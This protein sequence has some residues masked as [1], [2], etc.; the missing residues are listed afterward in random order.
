MIFFNKESHYGELAYEFHLSL[1]MKTSKFKM[2]TEGK[3]TPIAPIQIN[4][5]G[6][7]NTIISIDMAYTISLLHVLATGTTRYKIRSGLQEKQN[8]KK[9]KKSL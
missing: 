2:L 3:N 8:N 9:E 7:V 5:R 4:H 1:H 6:S